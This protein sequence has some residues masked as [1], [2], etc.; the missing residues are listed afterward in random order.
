[1]SKNYK[2]YQF[3]LSRY[4]NRPNATSTI[5]GMAEITGSSGN[6]RD[7]MIVNYFNEH[8]VDIPIDY[9]PDDGTNV[10]IWMSENYP[11]TYTEFLKQ[12]D[13]Q[14][15]L[16]SKKHKDYGHENLVAGLE[17]NDVLMGLFFRM[18]DKLN[19]FK[20]L[21]GKT[22]ELD[23]SLEDTLNDISNYANIAQIILKG[24]WGK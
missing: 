22:I 9:L 5:T 2:N 13:V 1:M 8:L 15:D 6:T 11:E 10:D 7:Q 21:I 17:P 4:L 3:E 24:K 19:R 16:F 20:N 18:N 12:Q 14:F 23:E